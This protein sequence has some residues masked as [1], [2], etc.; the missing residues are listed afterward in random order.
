MEYQNLWLFVLSVASTGLGWFLRVQWEQQKEM[1]KD[2]HN[3]ERTMLRDYTP[4]TK[5]KEMSDAIFERFDTFER[6]LDS[7]FIPL[8]RRRA[9]GD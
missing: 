1:A 9:T 7:L 4:N 8:E 5:M 3:L 2:L 6:K